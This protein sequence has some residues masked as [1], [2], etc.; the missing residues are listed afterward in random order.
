[1]AHRQT[2]G[3]MDLDVFFPQS[4]QDFLI[5]DPFFSGF[6]PALVLPSVDLMEQS[7]FKVPSWFAWFLLSF[8]AEKLE[9][10]FDSPKLGRYWLGEVVLPFLDVFFPLRII[11]RFKQAAS[12]I[13]L[14]FAENVDIHLFI[15]L[16]ICHR[17][18]Q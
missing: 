18:T 13:K 14:I 6:A 12:D 2:G 4:V 15:Q 8:R 10:P 7:Q 17:S 1:M 5:F 3:A 16:D 11:H 9:L